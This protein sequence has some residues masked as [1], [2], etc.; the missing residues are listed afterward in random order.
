MSD[1]TRLNDLK[2]ILELLYEKLGEFERELITRLGR[3][4]RSL[5]KIK[6]LT[7]LA[8]VKEKM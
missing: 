1:R 4:G 5:E 2:D 7:R 6:Y 3:L 8:P